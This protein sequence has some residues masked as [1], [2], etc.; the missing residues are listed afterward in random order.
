MNSRISKFGLGI[1]LMLVFTMIGPILIWGGELNFTLA[2]IFGW[3]TIFFSMI[4]LFI[5]MK[6]YRDDDAGG[7]I[8]FAGALK[9]GMLIALIAAVI[10]G[11]FTTILFTSA[12]GKEFIEVFQEHH[13][14]QT[15]SSDASQQEKEEQLQYMEDMQ[16][17]IMNPFFQGG[18]AFLRHVVVCFIFALGFAWYLKT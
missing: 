18:L 16:G 9:V 1:G 17:F 13:I 14:E 11:A 2:E 5:G 8:S 7:T 3:A 10:I 15:N 12:Q 4:F 6:G